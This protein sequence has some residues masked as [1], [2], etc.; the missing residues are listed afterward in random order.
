MRGKLPL[1]VNIY[2][3]YRITPA[4]AGKTGISLDSVYLF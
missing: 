2:L 3:T 1:Y 4:Y